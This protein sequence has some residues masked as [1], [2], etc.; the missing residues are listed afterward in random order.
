[1]GCGRKRTCPESPGRAGAPR[2]G[3]GS[4]RASSAPAGAARC[5]GRRDRS[6]RQGKRAAQPCKA[7]RLELPAGSGLGRGGLRGRWSPWSRQDW[8]SE[9]TRRALRRG[10]PE[11]GGSHG[12]EEWWLQ[13]H[14]CPSVPR[15]LSNFEGEVGEGS[16]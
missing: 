4:R 13:P 7:P 5:A 2:L 3:A 12:E 6:G 1:M 10:L 11:D 16:V 14:L 15:H 8:R 9:E